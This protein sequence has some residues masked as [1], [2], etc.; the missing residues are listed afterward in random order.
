MLGEA[1]PAC[2]KALGRKHRCGKSL[3]MRKEAPGA[4][5]GGRWWEGGGK[6][7]LAGLMA[8]VPELLLR[9]MGCV[10]LGAEEHG[11]ALLTEDGLQRAGASRGREAAVGRH[12]AG[13]WPGRGGS[14]RDVGTVAT[15][16]AVFWPG[17]LVDAAMLV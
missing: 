12:S 11:L 6:A 9:V 15:L 13:A 2:A 7:A 1:T 16:P 4:W 3:R 17:H 5:R 10:E 14:S 8:R